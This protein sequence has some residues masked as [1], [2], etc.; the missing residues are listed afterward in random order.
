ML[1][2][3][4]L[5][6][7]FNNSSINYFTLFYCHFFLVMHRCRAF[8]KP[9]CTWNDVNYLRTNLTFSILSSHV[10][11]CT[12][13]TDALFP[14]EQ[15]W[16]VLKLYNSSAPKGQIRQ[17]VCSCVRVYA[18]FL[19][20]TLPRLT[21]INFRIIMCRSIVTK[22]QQQ[23]ICLGELILSSWMTHK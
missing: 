19:W 22:M 11:P 3:G 23:V 21:D 16:Q 13:L 14:P 10:L 5:T 4:I 2:R 18:M 9:A 20:G 17:W 1:R 15:K 7:R 12:N 6:E 8:I